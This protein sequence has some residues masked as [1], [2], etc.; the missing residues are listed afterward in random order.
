MTLRNV[1]INVREVKEKSFI[2]KDGETIKFIEGYFGGD[3]FDTFTKF[4][5]NKV[6][7]DGVYNCALKVDFDFNKKVTKVK[8]FI[9]DN[10]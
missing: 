8:V 3:E 6:V 2:T 10:V 7:S 5:C 1:K 9:G 4:S